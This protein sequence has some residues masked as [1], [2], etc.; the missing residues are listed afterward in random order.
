MKDLGKLRY[1][2]GLELVRISQGIFVSQGNYMQ[3]LINE[4][5]LCGAKTS[6]LPMDPH[7]S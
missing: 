2:L 3:D 7:L 4:V 6:R 5:E 1:F